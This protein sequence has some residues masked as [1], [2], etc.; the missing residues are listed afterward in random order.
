MAAC[1]DCGHPVKHVSTA[2]GEQ[3]PIDERADQLIGNDRYYFPDPVNEPGVVAPMGAGHI[4]YGYG[5]HRKT[6]PRVRREAR[7]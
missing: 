3:F 5:D 6:C 4:G 7:L 2:D 1:S